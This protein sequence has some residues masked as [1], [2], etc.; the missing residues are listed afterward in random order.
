V[1]AFILIERVERLHLDFMRD[2]LGAIAVEA[3]AAYRL[4]QRGPGNW[5]VQRE[6]EAVETHY[7][8]RVAAMRAIHLA[9]V[10]CTAYRVRIKVEN[11]WH[12]IE[13]SD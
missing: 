4:R 7:P 8:S 11:A 10:R 5:V 1:E 2:A 6:G 13:S 3:P 9:V 12:V